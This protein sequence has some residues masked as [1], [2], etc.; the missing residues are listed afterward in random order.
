[1]GLILLINWANHGPAVW[2]VAL[3]ICAD[4]TSAINPNENKLTSLRNQCNFN[5]KWGRGTNNH[6]NHPPTSFSKP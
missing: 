1:M 3:L 6:R 5:P 2:I 4:K